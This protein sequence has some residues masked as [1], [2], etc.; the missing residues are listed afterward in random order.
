MSG[1]LYAGP[2]T[3]SA[4][5]TMRAIAYL[6]DGTTSAVV[7]AAYAISPPPPA[8]SWEAENLPFIAQGAASSVRSD[9]AAS[10]GRW[11]ALEANSVGD[12][13]ELTT[14]TLPA[15][16]YKIELRYKTNSNRGILG[17]KV[18]GSQ[19]GSIDQYARPAAY[20]TR[21]FAP[22]TFAAAGAHK[23]RLAVTGKNAGSTDYSLS[24]DRI[25][26]VRQ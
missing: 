4:T 12:Y 20:L 24:A 22:V 9:T 17:F 3:I 14:P 11:R 6:P 23:L 21:V 15:G 19:I 16:T 8:Q 13:L 18:D 7:S 26:F 25:A 10:G 5:T 2:V 1:I